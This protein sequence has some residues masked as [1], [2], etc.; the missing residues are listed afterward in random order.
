VAAKT[1]DRSTKSNIQNRRAAGVA[2]P[3]PDEMVARAVA[4]QPRLREQATTTEDRGY[5]PKEIHD[6]LVE[7][8]FYKLYVPKKYGG[9]EYSLRSFTKV[10]VALAEGCPSTAWFFAFGAGHAISLGSF[11]P[12]K[13][14]A[15]LF[16][17]DGNFQAPHSARAERCT[18]RPVDGGWIVNGVWPYC[19]GIQYAKHFMGT[20]KILNA[21]GTPAENSPPRTVVAVVPDNQ[22][23]VLD[24]WGGSLGMRGTGSHSVK[25]E[26]VF[27]PQE[28]A[29]D[30]ALFSRSE[31]A[32]GFSLHGNPIYQGCWKPN[33][34]GES[35]SVLIGATKSALEAYE[36]ILKTRKLVRTGIISEQ[37]RYMDVGH[38]RDFGRAWVTVASGQ[39]LLERA[40]D[41][42]Q[43]HLDRWANEGIPYT[44]LEEELVMHLV[45][46]SGTL[47]TNAM[48]IIFAA[49]GSATASKGSLIERCYRDVSTIKP[50]ASSQFLDNVTLLS[51]MHFGLTAPQAATSGG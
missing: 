50:H 24:D 8:G 11:Y 29:V 12:E 34:S 30:W 45:R 39:A 17:P 19:S 22:F 3:D 42:H 14:Q 13:V 43:E 1:K 38:Q 36:E 44:R 48:D 15:A 4:M 5:P 10:I 9:Y 7:S 35:M 6:Q 18:V 26:E 16:G 47:A 20:A 33:Y 2:I 21:D 23:T 51:R 37:L 41:M 40:A 31:P 28:Y 46:Q 25:V 27:I 49:A 32:P